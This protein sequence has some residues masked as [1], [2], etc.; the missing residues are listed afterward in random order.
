MSSETTT[1]ETLIQTFSRYGKLKSLKLV[2]DIVTGCS[3]KYA[4]V[5]YYYDEDFSS[6]FF[7]AHRMRLDDAQILVDFMREQT[8]PGWVPRRL[9]GGVGG[10]KSSGQMRFGGRDCPF[11]APFDINIYR[12]K[13]NGANRMRQEEWNRQGESGE[14]RK[15]EVERRDELRKDSVDLHGRE[16]YVGRSSHRGSARTRSRS[17]TGRRSEHNHSTIHD[18]SQSRTGSRSEHNHSTTYDR[19]QSRTHTRNHSTHHRS[20]SPTHDHNHSPSHHHS[21][22]HSRSHKR[23]HSH[24]SFPVCNNKECS[25]GGSNPRPS[26]Y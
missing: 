4:F 8:V 16:D 9:G 11:R 14:Q 19:S 17:R 24:K 15:R 2:R 22:T 25:N 13:Q 23:T 20:Q 26:R 18:R 7:G 1:E 5:E 21:H 3:M 10:K 12:S 6:A